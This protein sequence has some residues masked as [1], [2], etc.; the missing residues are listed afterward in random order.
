MFDFRNFSNILK[1]NKITSEKLSFFLKDVGIKL[2]KGTIDGYRKGNIKN[3]NILALKEVASICNI[4]IVDF[5]ENREII[6]KDITINELI[7][8]IDK[9][10][11]F[12]PK[13]LIPKDIK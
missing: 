2:E 8:N 10:I 6:K 4:S 1:K 11:D 12:L 13:E 7:N 9:Y 3:P 5:F